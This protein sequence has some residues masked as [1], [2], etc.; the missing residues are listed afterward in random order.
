MSS[1]ITCEVSSH[2]SPPVFKPLYN[3]ECL[4]V[5]QGQPGFPGIDGHKG[6]MGLQ[7]V[8]GFPGVYIQC[9]M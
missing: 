7:G 2:L 8:P 4:C 9:D 3:C 5:F 6:E 1:T